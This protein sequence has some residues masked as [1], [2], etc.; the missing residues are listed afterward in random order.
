[1]D[2]WAIFGFRNVFRKLWKSEIANSKKAKKELV[3][4]LRRRSSQEDMTG[5]GKRTKDTDSGSGPSEKS[6]PPNQK[7]QRLPSRQ[8]FEERRDF[9]MPHAPFPGSSDQQAGTSTSHRQESATKRTYWSTVLPSPNQQAGTSTS[10]RQHPLD[11]P[12]SQPY[13]LPLG[14]EGE[15]T[16]VAA[17]PEKGTQRYLDAIAEYNN[18][19]AQSEPVDANS[20]DPMD[21]RYEI[22][23]RINSLKTRNKGIVGKMDSIDPKSKELAQLE[24]EAQYLDTTFDTT[25]YFKI[26]QNRRRQVQ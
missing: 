3:M 19:Y 22:Y 6:D 23:T 26:I 14:P 4:E 11:R 12:S 17:R 24:F 13:D 8:T 15:A 10:H 18:M 5:K 1:M 2:G 20:F 16:K 21:R 9:Y 25:N 7:G